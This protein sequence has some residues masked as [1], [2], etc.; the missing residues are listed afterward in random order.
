LTT[1]EESTIATPDVPEQIP[2]LTSS[3]F[4]PFVL[5]GKER[6]AV[7]FM[8]Y[9]CTHCRAIEPILQKVAATLQAN[10]KI[11]RVNVGVERDLA[12]KY[13]IEGTPTLVMFLNGG[14]V[15]RVEGPH[16]TVASV[17]AAV[18]TPFES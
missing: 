9:G 13:A 11:F 15:G 1:R 2:T 8:S 17:T 6:I 4:K 3:T 5:E 12:S 10:E 14:E 16:P 18:T 7:E